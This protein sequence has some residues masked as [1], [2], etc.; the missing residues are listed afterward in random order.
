MGESSRVLMS[1]GAKGII[2]SWIKSY[3]GYLD[4]DM[5]AAQVSRGNVEGAVPLFGYGESVAGGALT[6][7]PL[8]PINIGPVVNVPSSSGVQMTV[9]S[10]SADDDKDDGTGARS[11]SLHYL[12]A[13]LNEQFEE[14]FLDGLTPVQTTATDIRFVQCTHVKTYGSLKKAVGNISV[15]TA[16]P[17]IYSYINAGYRRCS[18]SFRR[19]PA[20]KRLMIKSLHGGCISGSSDAKCVIRIVTTKI[21]EYDYTEEGFF[22]PVMSLVFQDNSV[23]LPLDMPV[24]VESGVIVGMEYDVDK[25]ATIAG[26]YSGYFEDVS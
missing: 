18:S 8:L 15:Y 11:L 5:Y 17:V 22:L 19:V 24:P 2:P 12:D 25:A 3:A 1:S 13:D 7:Q 21:D 26:G 23:S 16:G 10:T 20:G 14:V 9:A 4:D 6:N